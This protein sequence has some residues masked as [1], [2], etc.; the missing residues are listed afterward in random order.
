MYSDYKPNEHRKVIISTPFRVSR[1]HLRR[2][3]F[4]CL[5]MCFRMCAYRK[6]ALKLKIYSHMQPK[7]E[8]EYLVLLFTN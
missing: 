7:F 2:D 3:R 1:I 4:T 8:R 6:K 5:M